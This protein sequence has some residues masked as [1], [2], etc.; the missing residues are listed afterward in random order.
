VRLRQD[1]WPIAQ[2]GSAFPEGTAQSHLIIVASGGSQAGGTE[3]APPAAGYRG[4]ARFGVA[5]WRSAYDRRRSGT[6]VLGGTPTIIP[7]ND[8]RS[9]HGLWRCRA[10]IIAKR[11]ND[12]RS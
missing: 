7:A 12:H 4:V 10:H 3:D 8:S 11:V 5:V 6:A 9:T 1:T 2:S